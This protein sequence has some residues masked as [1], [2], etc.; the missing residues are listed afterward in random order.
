MT[1]QPAGVLHGLQQG[2]DNRSLHFVR[3]I[4][5]HVK[6][7]GGQLEDGHVVD[8]VADRAP[9]VAE[10]GGTPSQG[11]V[12]S[13]NIFIRGSETVL[14]CESVEEHQAA[15]AESGGAVFLLVG[16]GNDVGDSAGDAGVSGDLRR[17]LFQRVSDDGGGGDHAVHALQLQRKGANLVSKVGHGA[18]PD[19]TLWAGNSA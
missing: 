15:D 8:V 9:S 2:R 11:F 16:A 4:D 12:D 17:R 10:T 13:R 1:L 5:E 19:A 3:P 14:E 7:V 6:D 18:C